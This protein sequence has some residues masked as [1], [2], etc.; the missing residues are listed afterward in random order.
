M[1]TKSKKPKVAI[2]VDRSRDVLAAR[3]LVGLQPDDRYH[4]T[5]SQVPLT[6]RA[7]ARYDALVIAGHGLA[8]YS[9]RELDAVVGFVRR[10]GGLL[11]AGSAGVFERYTGRPAGEMAVAAIARRFGIEFLPPSNAAGRPKPNQELV[12]GY[13]GRSVRIHKAAPVR[14]L[15]RYDVCLRQWSPVQTKQRHTTLLSH[16][17][18]GEAAALAVRFARGRVI[19]VGNAGFLTESPLLRRCLLDD[20]AARRSARGPLPY[21]ILPPLRTRRQGELA[22]RYTEPVAGRVPTVLRLA[23]KILPQLEALIPAKHR[24]KGQ[25]LCIE[26]LPGCTARFAWW[27]GGEHTVQLGADASDAELAFAMAR[28]VFEPVLWRTPVG[29]QLHASVLGGIALGH[30]VGLM[31]MR[32]AGFE[33]E[34]DGLGEA[35]E[36]AFFRRE[37]ANVTFGRVSKRSV[38]EAL[39][40]TSTSRETACGGRR[41]GS[42][43][44]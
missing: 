29:W 16:R 2:L 15:K 33:A 40:G 34:G 44:L 5:D 19:A 39:G 4:T 27:R 24:K 30:W 35:L 42:L 7:L 36:A 43:S 20:L 13:P 8:T 32:W 38:T 3:D 41:P 28:H 1:S 26:L 9:A 6:A 10:G 22:V 12:D 31:A 37:A 21:E 18:T 11:L 23:R 25:R 17:R 14:G